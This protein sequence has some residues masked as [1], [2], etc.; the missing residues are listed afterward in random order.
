MNY[1]SSNFY[2]T[3][4]NISRKSEKALKRIINLNKFKSGERLIRSVRE[5]YKTVNEK[6]RCFI[7]G[8]GPS[9]TVQD[10]DTLREHKETCIASNSIYNLFGQTDWRPDIYTVHDF[11]EI[12]KTHDKISAVKSELKIA[13]QSAAGRIYDIDGAITLRLIEPEESRETVFFSDDI[14]KCIY[15]GGTV[16]YVSIQC[17]VYLGFREIILLGVDH[18]F[19]REERK[20]GTVEINNMNKNHFTNYQTEDFWGN[21]KSDE[22]TVIFPVDF[23]T[24]AFETAKQYADAHGIKIL[25][26]TRGGKLEVFARVNFDS[27]F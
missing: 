19:A 5:K 17:A 22:E 12:K 18:S 25:N 11:Q 15:D 3:F 24:M 23:A 14:S 20:D 9:L 7:I 10:L 6:R 1:R 26:A 13:A 4:R 21:N 16:T 27:L 8:N 2:L